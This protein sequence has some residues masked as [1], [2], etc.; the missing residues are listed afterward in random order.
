MFFVTRRM[1]GVVGWFVDDGV[2][3]TTAKALADGQGYRHLEL[4]GDP[5]QTKYPI[6][7]PLVLSGV[8]R[9]WPDFPANI[10]AFQVLNIALWTIGSWIAYRLMC[11]TWGLPWWLPAI[12][13]V[14]AF[15]NYMTLELLRTPMSEPLYLVLSAAALALA[16]TADPAETPHSGRRLV[17]LALVSGVLAAAA[18]L[19]RSIGIS[20]MAAVP[21]GW[22]VNRRW[23][24]A[25]LAAI[26][27]VLAIA[28]WRAWCA[29][30]AGLNAA[31]PAAAVMSYDL[32]YAAWLPSLRTIAWVVY[33][34]VS[35]F[36]LALFDLL[37]PWWTEDEKK[38][39]LV[40]G[41][42]AAW[43]LYLGMVVASALTL[44]GLAAT[45][46]RARAAIHFYLLFYTGLVLAWPFAAVRFI[47]PIL[48]LVIT[49]QL[50]GLYLF[51][52]FL[53]GVLARAAGPRPTVGRAAVPARWSASRPGASLAFRLVIVPALLLGYVRFQPLAGLGQEIKPRH[54]VEQWEREALVDLLCAHTPRDA[55][56]SAN[57]GGYFYLRT[58]RKFVPPLPNDDLL[59]VL[60]PRDRK[61]SE[62]GRVV[63]P[64][65]LAADLH[66]T[67]QRFDRYVRTT[68]MTFLVPLETRDSSYWAVFQQLCRAEPDRFRLVGGTPVYALYQVSQRPR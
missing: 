60:Y 43:P 7:Y 24:C 57:G 45:W 66:F 54:G 28:G 41:L 29:Y 46:N 65:M 12:G 59:A 55:V 21:L 13:V 31:N 27:P 34:N 53:G 22:A 44:A 50:V 18:Y 4:P 5:Y 56:I 16:C 49:L 68:G 48:P 42:D 40:R 15:A 14:L 61:F 25:V 62:C 19:A 38:E 9:L 17:V 32:N 11:R 30:A 2:Y 36:A 37:V 6:L 35:D 8:W 58:G 33:Q 64:G 52:L 3:L 39:M 51:G 63:T 23:K 47:V 26:G 20:V 10:P 67:T 1:P